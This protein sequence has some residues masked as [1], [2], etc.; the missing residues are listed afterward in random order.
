MKKIAMPALLALFLCCWLGIPGCKK[1]PGQQSNSNEIVIGEYASLTGGTADFGKSSHQGLLLAIDQI[2]A[3]GGLLGKQLRLVTLD[4]RSDVNE[5]VTAVERLINREN[6]IAIIGE[7]ASKRSIAGAGV[8]EKYKIPM[9]SPASTNPEVTVTGGKV[10]DYAFRICF[11]DDFQGSIDGRFGVEKGWKKVALLTN[12]DEDYSKGLA[13][14]FRQSAEASMTIVA[15][16]SYRNSDRD[17]KAQLDKI[18][19]ANPD[20]VYVP[21]YYTEMVLMLP[22]A[23]EVGLNVPFFGGD[24]WDSPDTVK[25]PAAQGCFYTDHFAPDDPSPRVQEFVKAYQAANNGITP[26]AMAVL[27]YDSGMVIAD[28]IQRA[29]KVDPAA[30]RDALATTKNYPGAS[31]DI[32]IDENHNARKPIVMLKIENLKANLFQKFDADGKLV[33]P[34]SQPAVVAP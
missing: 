26:G 27:G 18:S 33:T 4:D 3:K 10:K 25:L 7:V 28:A 9:L 17:F 19:R 13:K 21:G 32:T 31:G 12:N 29:G 6:A 16:E 14:F 5:A 24:G 1:K 15:D 23:K 30:I 2:N 11:T 34:T 8:C 22:Q 20:A